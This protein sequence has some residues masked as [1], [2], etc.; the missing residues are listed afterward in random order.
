MQIDSAVIRTVGQMGGP[1]VQKKADRE[2]RQLLKVFSK[3]SRAIEDNPADVTAKVRERPD[4][5]KAELEEF[6][7]LLRVP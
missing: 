2:A 6:R 7:K 5:P 4:V 3:V 1:L